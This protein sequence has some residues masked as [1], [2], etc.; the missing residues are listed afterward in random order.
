MSKLA[1]TKGTAVANQIADKYCFQE[2]Y[3]TTRTAA[4]QMAEK[5][6]YLMTGEYKGS[7]ANEIDLGVTNVAQGSV[8]VTAGGVTLVENTD[9]T[10]DYSMGRVTIINQSIIDAGTNVSAS[11]ESNDT[12]DLQRKTFLGLNFD[13]EY[14]KNL[15]FG[16]TVQYL[17]EQPLTT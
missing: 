12:Y 11:V 6:K 3:D 9:Y 7:S 1:P 15:T 13:Y 10:V 8:V 2:L 14:S 5:N 17:S 16:G 4:K